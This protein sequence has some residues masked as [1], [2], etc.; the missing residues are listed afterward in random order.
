VVPL[1]GD[2]LQAAIQKPAAGVGVYLE[3]ALVERLMQDGANEPG[4]LPLM[5]E[6][7]VLVWS[8]LKRRLLTLS[9]YESL[10]SAEQTGL[11]AAILIRADAV[12]LQLTAE[13]RSIARRAFLRL[14]QFG[15]GRP[16]TRRQQRRGALGSAGEDP[17]EFD[18]TISHLIDHHLLIS[19]GRERGDNEQIDIAHESLITGWPSLSRWV[20]ERRIAERSRRRLEDKAD[21]WMSLGAGSGGLLDPVALLEAERWLQSPDATDLGHS[22]NL[23]HLIAVSREEAARLEHER[24]MGLRRA[25]R[26]KRILVALSAVLV[27]SSVAT[28]FCTLAAN[29]RPR[30]RIRNRF[31]GD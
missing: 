16:D 12:L 29:A 23:D 17:A 27:T 24:E 28:V 7:L 3:P 13:Q 9:T 10:G 31:S 19:G 30:S 8:R 18:R 14:V 4:V 20:T 2:A 5:Q 21:E 25:I 26:Q 6:T 1:R 15:E 22:A 11:A